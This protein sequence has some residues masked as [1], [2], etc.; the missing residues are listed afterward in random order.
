MDAF[1]PIVRN[2]YENLSSK[3]I[4]FFKVQFETSFY[5]S[6]GSLVEADFEPV[7][8]YAHVGAVSVYARLV[9]RIVR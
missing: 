1:G 6:K 5:T 4:G 3:K 8:T 9:A 7:V 2:G